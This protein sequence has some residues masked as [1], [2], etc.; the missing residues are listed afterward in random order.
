MNGEIFHEYWES[1]NKLY[2]SY[3]QHQISKQL[4]IQY[5]YAGLLPIDKNMLDAISG[6][7]WLIRLQL[8]L[9]NCLISWHKV[10]NSLD[11]EKSCL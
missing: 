2:A 4:L 11:L 8:R 6:G 7:L 1:F 3:P 5:L 10:L 9:G